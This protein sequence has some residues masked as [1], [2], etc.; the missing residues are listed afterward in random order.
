MLFAQKYQSKAEEHFANALML[1]REGNFLKALDFLLQS[2]SE[3][4]DQPRANA[5]IEEVTKEIVLKR[6]EELYSQGMNSYEN[7]NFVDAVVKFS[8]A[9]SLAPSKKR[10]SDS[11]RNVQ[12]A[13]EQE[14]IK[15]QKI[16]FI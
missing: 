6:V 2:L 14:A 8:E 16:Y 4:K 12:T 5:L 3:E 7:G 10:I 11:L 9:L 15:K 13:L 1:Y